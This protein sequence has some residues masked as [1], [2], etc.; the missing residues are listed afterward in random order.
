MSVEEQMLTKGI[1]GRHIETEGRGDGEHSE[2]VI[3]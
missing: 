3:S 1:E 2:G